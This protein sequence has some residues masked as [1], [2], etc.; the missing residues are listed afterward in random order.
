MTGDGTTFVAQQRER[1]SAVN[2]N[3]RSGRKYL[4]ADPDH[5]A[6]IPAD[7]DPKQAAPLICAGITTYKGTKETKA[8]PGEWIV[9]SGASGLGHL[10]IQ[11][12]KMMGLLSAINDV[13]DRL[14]HGKVAGRVVLDFIGTAAH[15]DTATME[16]TPEVESVA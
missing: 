11:Y 9:I 13:F 4:I 7:L 5:I 3:H 14:K 12:A 15:D 16:R 10:A 1:K 8:K 2:S 6:H